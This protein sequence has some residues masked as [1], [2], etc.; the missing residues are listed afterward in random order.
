MRH[1]VAGTIV[2]FV[3]ILGAAAGGA[4]APPLTEAAVLDRASA[5][6]REYEQRF[7]LLVAEERYVQEIRRPE[8]NV[9]GGG[10]LSR[11]NP[12]GG[13][14]GGPALRK[15]QT[16]RSDYLLVSLGA[17]GGWMPF[18][19]TFELDGRTLADRQDRLTKLFLEP[20][21]STLERA[22]R[23]MAD[24]T[25]YN[26]GSIER[27]VNIPTLA[28]MF[29]HPDI[30]PRFTFT[31]GDDET[32]AGRP[33]WSFSYTER[34]RPTLIKTSRGHDLPATGVIWI[35]PASGIVLKT[36]LT[37]AD[38]IVRALVT[39]TYRDD[40]GVAFWIPDRMEDYYKAARDIDEISGEATY[41]NYRK[42]SVNTDEALRKPPPE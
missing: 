29:L 11:T 2:A 39:T 8:G 28:L 42:F 25:R 21:G 12:G 31:R 22:A 19:D 7:A 6:V 26:L 9:T 20:S 37:A 18:R 36:S 16:L 5:Y 14:N 24:S 23:I 10:N 4:Q 17:G 32:V 13:F 27:T 3:V 38:P 35:D 34:Q 1:S 40:P 33:A 15:R 41:T 30:R